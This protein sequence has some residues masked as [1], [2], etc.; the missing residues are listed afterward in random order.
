MGDQPNAQDLMFYQWF[1]TFLMVCEMYEHLFVMDWNN[2]C[3]D[4]YVKELIIIYVYYE[5]KAE[6]VSIF[7][8]YSAKRK[9][10]WYYKQWMLLSGENTIKAKC[11][12]VCVCVCGVKWRNKLIIEYI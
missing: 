6:N 9:I 3:V 4:K 2:S 12:C 7:R 11:V 8:F 10:K 5:N 1:Q